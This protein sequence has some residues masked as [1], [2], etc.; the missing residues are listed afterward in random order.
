MI[1]LWKRKELCNQKNNKVYA[2]SKKESANLY[3][4]IQNYVFYL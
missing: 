3:A 2:Q 4:D 1:T